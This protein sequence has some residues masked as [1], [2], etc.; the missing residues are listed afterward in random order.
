[1][2][3][4]IITAQVTES[5]SFSKWLSAKTSF[6]QLEDLTYHIERL[7]SGA[8]EKHKASDRIETLSNAYEEYSDKAGAIRAKLTGK[9]PGYLDRCSWFKTSYN[10]ATEY[11]NTLQNIANEAKAEAEAIDQA[12]Q[13]L[14]ADAN[15]MIGADL[16]SAMTNE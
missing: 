3:H 12:I 11:M 14:Q 5:D 7:E 2:K 4:T 10:K 1:M 16:A 15:D 6:G 9:T 13:G 8:L